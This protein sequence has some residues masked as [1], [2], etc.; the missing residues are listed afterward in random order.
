MHTSNPNLMLKM[1]ME[2]SPSSSTTVEDGEHS[3]SYPALKTTGG[4]QPISAESA[5]NTLQ[6][7][8]FKV[9]IALLTVASSSGRQRDMLDKPCRFVVYYV[10]GIHMQ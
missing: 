5:R 2:S 10:C 8:T 3:I 6:K 9:G 1:I 7:D 4:H